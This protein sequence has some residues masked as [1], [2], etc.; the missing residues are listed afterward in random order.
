M[1]SHK[2]HSAVLASILENLLDRQTDRPK[3]IKPSFMFQYRVNNISLYPVHYNCIYCTL[4]MVCL[5]KST[6][7]AHYFVGR[8]SI[9]RSEMSELITSRSGDHLSR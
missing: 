3:I 7:K 2:I 9:R 6:T 1:S 8:E 5:T 4:V